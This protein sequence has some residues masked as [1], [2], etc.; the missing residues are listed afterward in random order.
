[1]EAETR[2][3]ASSLK[4]KEVEWRSKFGK[5]PRMTRYAMHIDLVCM[6]IVY[7]CNTMLQHTIHQRGAVQFRQ[8]AHAGASC[9]IQL[10]AHSIPIRDHADRHGVLQAIISCIQSIKKIIVFW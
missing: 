2:Q 9:G 3:I 6:S 4:T 5:S 10:H 1:V 8:A 7:T